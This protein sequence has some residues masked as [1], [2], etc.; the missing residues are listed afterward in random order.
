MNNSTVRLSRQ[1]MIDS[2]GTGDLEV[3]HDFGCM[4]LLWLWLWLLVLG[5]VLSL[6]SGLMV[7]V[8]FV[9]ALPSSPHLSADYEI[10]LLKEGV[11]HIDLKGVE[12]G[13]TEV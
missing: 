4:L 1:A 5:F 9:Y 11:E 6:L 10:K 13:E 2:G 12:F 3:E 8:S 7:K